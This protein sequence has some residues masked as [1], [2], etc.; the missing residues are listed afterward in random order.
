MKRCC[1]VSASPRR[2]A[3]HE[4][5]DQRPRLKRHPA[6]GSSV[7]SSRRRTLTA[8]PGVQRCQ[9]DLT[10]FQMASAANRNQYQLRNHHAATMS[11]VIAS[12][13]FFVSG[14]AHRDLVVRL[15]TRHAQGNRANVRPIQACVV[16]CGPLLALIWRWAGQLSVAGDDAETLAGN[17][18]MNM[19]LAIPDEHLYRRPRQVYMLAL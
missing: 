15:K 18:V 3:S 12:R 8:L 9:G 1:A 14:D 11:S 19:I 4:G 5:I 13:L 16:E 2:R 10:P 6:T 7:G 17:L